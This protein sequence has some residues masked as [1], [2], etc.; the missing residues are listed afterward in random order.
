MEAAFWWDSINASRLH[1]HFKKENARRKPGV[2]VYMEIV[3]PSLH[4][5]GGEAM[6]P[7]FRSIPRAFGH[8]LGLR[9]RAT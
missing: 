1:L 9:R 4:H 2:R 3:L 5:A 6:L 8:V 7:T